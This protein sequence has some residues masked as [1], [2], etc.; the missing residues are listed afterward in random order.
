MAQAILAIRI[1]YAMGIDILAFDIFQIEPALEL[2]LEPPLEAPPD[3]RGRCH[4]GSVPLSRRPLDAFA[5]PP[6]TGAALAG[7]RFA[8][9]SPLPRRAY[10]VVAFGEQLCQG[11]P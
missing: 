11:S 5:A 2:P 10:E 9:G 7:R 4:G 1:K 3:E 8:A 6:W